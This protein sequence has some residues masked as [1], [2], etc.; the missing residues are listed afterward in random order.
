MWPFTP[1][2]AFAQKPHAPH[3]HVGYRGNTAEDARTHYCDYYSTVVATHG[4]SGIWYSASTSHNASRRK[5]AMRVDVDAMRCDAMRCDAV[6]CGAVRTMD[7]RNCKAQ[8]SAKVVKPEQQA[9]QQSTVQCTCISCACTFL[10][11]TKID[12]GED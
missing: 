3:W 10:T 11:T 6:R 7:R 2:S 5:H 4:D 9:W 12:E 1:R 8:K